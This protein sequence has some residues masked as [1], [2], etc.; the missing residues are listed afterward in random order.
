MEPHNSIMKDQWREYKEWLDRFIPDRVSKY[1]WSSNFER[2]LLVFFVLGI[3]YLVGFV[4]FGREL[5][6]KLRQAINVVL[7]M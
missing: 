3:L 2:V 6:E 7:T 4:F 1:L 5:F